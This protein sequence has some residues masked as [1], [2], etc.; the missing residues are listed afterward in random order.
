MQVDTDHGVY[1]VLP[2]RESDGP[3]GP[4]DSA[5]HTVFDESG[6][7]AGYAAE[8]GWAWDA[9]GTPW[10]RPFGSLAAAAAEVAE[11]DDG[12][13]SA[14]EDEMFGAQDAE[15]DLGDLRPDA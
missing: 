11:T 7:I 14:R 12:G 3:A 2:A 1:D 6:D 4:P 13:A 5:T 15:L 9:G 10:P 8:S